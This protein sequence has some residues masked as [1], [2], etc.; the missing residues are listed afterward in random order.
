MRG[1]SH[2]TKLGLIDEKR[3]FGFDSLFDSG[4]FAFFW[5]C[6]AAE[7]KEDGRAGELIDVPKLV[8]EIL[9]IALG[10][11]RRF[12][13]EDNKLRRSRL[14]LRHV[15]DAEALAVEK[16]RVASMEASF[17]EFIELAR[18]DFAIAL[19]VYFLHN[20]EDFV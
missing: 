2:A 12:I 1:S 16:R 7:F 4:D 15:I 11:E 14:G 9:S 5:L 8:D 17:D 20:G 19:V 10:H 13:D 18:C 3:L 6:F